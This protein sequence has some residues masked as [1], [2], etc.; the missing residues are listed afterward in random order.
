[1][2]LS[3]HDLID[4]RTVGLQLV[5]GSTAPDWTAF[6]GV[7]YHVPNLDHSHRV[8]REQD[9]MRWVGRRIEICC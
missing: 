7:L 9:E 4:P 1:M 6:R 8:G 5:A 2:T 3:I